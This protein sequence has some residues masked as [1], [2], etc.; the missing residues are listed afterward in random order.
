M[1]ISAAG[2]LIQRGDGKILILLRR[3]E[4]SEGNK[5]GIP[6]GKNI[7]G[8][9]DDETAITK[10]KQE[11]GLALDKSDLKLLGTFQYRV[12]SNDINFTVFTVKISD[13]QIKQLVLNPEGHVQLDWMNPHEA[14]QREDLMVGMYPIL[15][16]FN[17]EASD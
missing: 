15:Q 7:R 9:T 4:V 16:N 5:W 10:S 17:N 14:L 6:G 2:I 11:V 8:E 3:P 12:D 13:V 1:K